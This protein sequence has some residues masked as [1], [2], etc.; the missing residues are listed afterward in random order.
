MKYRGQ[1]SQHQGEGEAQSQE[2]TYPAGPN[3]NQARP[4]RSRKDDAPRGRSFRENNAT[5]RSISASA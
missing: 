1:E 5:E 2:D 4:G 3:P